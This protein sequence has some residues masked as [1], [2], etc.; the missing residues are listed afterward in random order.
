MHQQ[1]EQGGEPLPC[2]IQS[3]EMKFTI[4]LAHIM[5]F[6]NVAS[7]KTYLPDAIA[8]SVVR[9]LERDSNRGGTDVAVRHNKVVYR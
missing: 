5:L 3:A 4:T 2:T 8:T 7:G 9:N 1:G 6:E